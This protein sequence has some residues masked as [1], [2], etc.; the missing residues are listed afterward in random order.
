MKSLC[1]RKIVCYVLLSPVVPSGPP[2]G[3]MAQNITTTSLTLVW[4][5]PE[6]NHANGIIMY[7][8]IC[9]QEV[10]LGTDCTSIVSIPQEQMSFDITTGLRPYTQYVLVVMAAT[11][12]VG[13]GPKAMI[14]ETTLTAGRMLK[15]LHER[16]TAWGLANIQT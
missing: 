2:L 10:S 7:Y 9:Y 5:P 3:L 1:I 14:N 4:L 12:I 13:W 8:G 11:K 16:N 15:S 6:Y